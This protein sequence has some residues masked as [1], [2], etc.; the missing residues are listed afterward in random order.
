MKTIITPLVKNQTYDILE[1]LGTLR[2]KFIG[3]M[4]E[5]FQETLIFQNQAGIGYFGAAWHLD[6]SDITNPFPYLRSTH[7]GY[8]AESL[9]LVVCQSS[10]R[11]EIVLFDD[12]N[13]TQYSKQIGIN[14]GINCGI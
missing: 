11:R 9:M 1:S 7:Y 5:G 14:T 3:V 4:T 6:L 2:G 12:E 10:V 13:K 8:S